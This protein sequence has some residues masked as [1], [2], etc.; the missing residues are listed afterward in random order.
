M[1]NFNIKLTLKEKEDEI[2]Q[3]SEEIE[4]IKLSD[5]KKISFPLVS[6]M[7]KLEDMPLISFQHDFCNLMIFRDSLSISIKKEEEIIFLPEEKEEKMEIFQFDNESVGKFSNDFNFLLGMLLSSFNRT[8]FIVNKRM[9]INID[10]KDPMVQKTCIQSERLKE[11]EHIKEDSVF[12]IY[13]IRLERID[14]DSRKNTYTINEDYENKKAS[15]I[16]TSEQEGEI[17]AINLN[18]DIDLILGD[19]RQILNKLKV[20]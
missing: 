14:K 8:D 5:F 15:I 16:Y 7:E 20:A 2:K 6:I 11:L 10:I 9:R 4:K 17:K 19:V 12:R 18:D 1:E 13:G 3:F